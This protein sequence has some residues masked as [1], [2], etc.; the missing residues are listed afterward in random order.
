M[1]KSNQETHTE[2]TKVYTNYEMSDFAFK[3]T[4]EKCT[5]SVKCTVYLGQE[6]ICVLTYI[7]MKITKQNIHRKQ[8]KFIL[9]KLKYKQ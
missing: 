3:N 5:T 6:C 7:L 1:H 2:Q 9:F 4:V 8:N